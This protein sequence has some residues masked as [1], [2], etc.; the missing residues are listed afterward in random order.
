MLST[1]LKYMVEEQSNIINIIFFCISILHSKSVI[2]IGLCL[3]LVD[4]LFSLI[5]T[6]W[7]K[8]E[9]SINLENDH[10]FISFSGYIIVPYR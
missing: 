1:E 10:L 8:V 4:N 2:L 6:Q 5:F 3:G 7:F 9:F